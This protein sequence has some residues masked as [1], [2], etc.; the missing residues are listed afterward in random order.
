MR[1]ALAI[2]IA[3][4]FIVTVIAVCGCGGDASRAK[5]YMN[6]GDALLKTV[7]GQYTSIS[8]KMTTL[9]AEYT[10]GKNTEPTAVKAKIAEITG[11]L[12]AAKAGQDA[13]S[14]EY[15]KIL[16]LKGVPDY[17]KYAALQIEVIDKLGKANEEVRV[18]LDVVQASSTTGQPPDVQKLTTL[19]TNLQ[20]LS[21]E[22]DTLMKQANDL[23]QSKNLG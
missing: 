22:I 10:A 15:G 8:R 20:K 16:S 19:S 1:K 5:D 4:A 7:E 21:G 17:V 2:T 3:L 12:D 9:I 23:K 18:M 6:K 14:A 13:A 11:L